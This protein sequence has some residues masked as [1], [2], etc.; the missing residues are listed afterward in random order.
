M[1]DSLRHYGLLPARLLGFSR[2]EYW[3]GFPFPPPGD[4]LNPEVEP[5]SPTSPALAGGFFTTEPKSGCPLVSPNQVYLNKNIDKLN[6]YVYIY[7]CIYIH[8]CIYVYMCVCVY[9]CVCVYMCIY[10]CTHI[11]II[12]TNGSGLRILADKKGRPLKY[13]S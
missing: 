2:Q 9:I 11:Y 4:L 6:M 7:M 13:L 1:S 10:V 3:S 12:I 8:M 5:A